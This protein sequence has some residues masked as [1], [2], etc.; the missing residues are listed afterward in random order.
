VSLALGIALFG[1]NLLY[2]QDQQLR[3]QV[4]YDENSRLMTLNRQQP[5]NVVFKLEKPEKLG[6]ATVEVT[7]RKIDQR[8]SITPTVNGKTFEA[9]EGMMNGATHTIRVEEKDLQET[10]QLTVTGDFTDV[11]VNNAT[12]QHVTVKG[13]AGSQRLLFLILN[14]LSIMIA[15]GPILLLKYRQYSKRNIYEKQFPNFLRDVVEGTRAGMSLPQAIKN[16]TNNNYQDMTPFVQ[17]MGAKLDWGIPFE[18]VM[19]YF[20][21]RTHSQIIQRAATSPRYWTPSGRT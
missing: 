5:A 10:N 19:T 3:D 21:R 16:T 7:F 20:G 8:I 15:L 14:V 9:R 17:E 2:Y 11:P 18:T 4:S 1:G 12:I 13:T 6:S